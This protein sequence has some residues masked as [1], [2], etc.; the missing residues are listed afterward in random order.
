MRWRSIKTR[1]TLRMLGLVLLGMAALAYDFSSMLREDLQRMLGDQQ[2]SVVSLAAAGIDRDISSRLDM[3]EAV[4][5]GVTPAMMRD[6][7]K[8]RAHLQDSHVFPFVFNRGAV[9][10]QT[11]GTA[12]AEVP[13][14]SAR[15]GAKDAARGDLMSALQGKAAIGKPHLSEGS[16][17][18]EFLMSVPILSPDGRVMGVL[19]GITQLNAPNFL[20]RYVG[21]SY[22]TSGGYVLI[23]REHRL[24]VTATDRSRLLEPLPAPGLVPPM[25]NFLRGQDG[26]V[27]MFDPL[28]Q[29]LL[30]AQK[31]VPNTGWL[32]AV[33]LPTAEAFAPIDRLQIRMLAAILGLA[34]LVGALT[35]WLI[36]RELSPM[37]SAVQ[38][39]ASLADSDQPPQPLPIARRDEIGKLIGS[40]NRLLE[41]L[42]HREV[43]LQQ[44][45]DTSSVA[46]YLIDAQGHIN[47]VNRRMADMFGCSAESLNGRDYVSLLHPSLQEAG[48]KNMQ[49]LLAN[50]IDRAEVD[51]IYCRDDS[52]E[53]WG[54]LTCR[55]F[56][57]AS[58]KGRFI[59][60]VIADITE[61]KKVHNALKDSEHRY[62]TLIEWS[63]DAALM[64]RE[65]VLIY[66]NAAAIALFGARAMSD[67]V[68]RQLIDLV[69][70][71]A[72][73]FVRQ[74]MQQQNEQ[75][76]S[77]PRAETRFVKLDGS[78]IDVEVQATPII[79]DGQRTHYSIIRDITAIKR[80]QAELRIAAT[81]FESQQG[82][83]ITNAQGTILRTNQAFTRITGY[84]AEEALGQNPRLL[85]SGRH[86]AAFYRVMWDNLATRGNWQGEIWNRRRDGEIYPEWLSI[87][88]V[89]DA[90]GQVGHYVATFFDISAR[91]TAE[92]QINNLAFYDP[93]TQ[94][95]NRRLLLDRLAQA[96]ITCTRHQSCGAL[97]YVDLD[98]FKTI[99]ETLGHFQGDL[100][101]ESVAQR[102]SGCVREGDTVARMGGDEFVVMLED[103]S[104]NPME[105]GTQ[106]EA[107]GEKIRLSLNRSY[108]IGTLEHHSTPSIGVTLFGEAQHETVEEP[109]KRA[110]LAMY[111]A[112]A[113][114]RNALRFFD[115]QMQVVVALRAA[116]EADLSE[117]LLQNQLLLHYQAQVVGGGRLT[118]AEVLVRWQHPKR[119]LVSPAEFIPLAEETGLIVPLGQWV[120]ETACRQLVAWST[121]PELSDLTLAVNV[122]AKQFHQVDF[123]AQV[124]AIL[125]RTGINP[126]RLKLEL[127]ESLMVND[128]E[129]IIAKMTSL[130]AAGVGFSLDDF[131]TGYSSL[132]YLK[133]LPLDQLKI[134]QGFVR[135]I[136]TDTNDAAIAKM[137]VALAESMGL[138]VIAEGV[139]LAA[140]KDFLARLGCHAY[141]GYFFSR[142]LALAEFEKL[143]RLAVSSAPGT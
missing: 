74:R 31:G 9:A 137:V 28:G 40:F 130:K 72:Q 69:A 23:S 135:N 82:I 25:D 68:G 81:A 111:Q 143:A 91:K 96:L 78:F 127:T 86:D 52:T 88:A 101:L 117:A 80:T 1:I 42:R 122:S 71:E 92:Q 37:L 94:L 8:L 142:P 56:M 131:G 95:P 13:L 21:Q 3:L 129:G 115:A 15:V 141:Q 67:L 39:L 6:V 114:G 125:T 77:L 35:W 124:Q 103:L 62:S 43:F 53:F 120:L 30:V 51:R 65:G 128:V 22:G 33:T 100:L 32:L 58:G 136:L 24:V 113:A 102:L 119:G 99:N 106:A 107:V 132:S 75:G 34:L 63:P 139:E 60:C 98:N 41:T 14:T 83:T 93:L 12:L 27:V 87:S 55:S 45:L 112:K 29:A 121:Q 108:T 48:Y 7:S 38:T 109:L 11:D 85:A 138:S 46:I 76:G 4:A 104:D 73:G 118:G 123:V 47:H 134:D 61:G 70:P 36:K 110:E 140:Q 2:F 16:N 19:A 97:L 59:V 79:Y 105:A 90:A 20:D 44:I 116:L 64:H 57:D 133:R 50:T 84:S 5:A 54:H 18:A 89:K 26:V 10:Y 49:A 126:K 66:A 17:F